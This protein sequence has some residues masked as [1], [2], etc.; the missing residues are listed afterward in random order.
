MSI[1]DYLISQWEKEHGLDE[2][3]SCEWFTGCEGCGQ[4]GWIEIFNY[5]ELEGHHYCDY[6][7]EKI[8]EKGNVK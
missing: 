6:C 7:F 1:S 4:T 5:V 8:K 2:T 3:Y